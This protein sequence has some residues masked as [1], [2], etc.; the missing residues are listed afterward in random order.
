MAS[1]LRV[2]LILVVILFC[3]I[4][5]CL[6]LTLGV[7]MMMMMVVFFSVSFPIM[8]NPFASVVFTVRIA[9]L[10]EIS[11]W[12]TF[13]LRLITVLAGDFNTVFDRSLDRRGSDLTDSSWESSSSL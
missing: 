5:L 10:L 6:W 12:M 2:R 1:F 3:V 4:L 8:A 9:T 7:M 13:I 11:S